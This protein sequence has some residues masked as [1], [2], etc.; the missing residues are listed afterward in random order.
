L[1]SSSNYSRWKKHI[2]VKA[3]F[4]S[5][6]LI[7][8]RFVTAILK[9]LDPAWSDAGFLK[10][11]LNHFWKDNRCHQSILFAIG[12]AKLCVPKQGSLTEG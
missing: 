11:S 3:N 1:H 10:P 8:Q 12:S 7:L 2:I 6:V 5:L 4:I 9:I